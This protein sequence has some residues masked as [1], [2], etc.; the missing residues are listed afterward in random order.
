MPSTLATVPTIARSS[1][2]GLAH[3]RDERNPTAKYHSFLQRERRT[4]ACI[5]SHGTPSVGPP[6]QHLCRV[7]PPKM[8]FSPA[9]LRRRYNSKSKTFRESVGGHWSW[10]PGSSCSCSGYPWEPV[11]RYTGRRESGTCTHRHKP[12]QPRRPTPHLCKNG[13]PLCTFRIRTGDNSIRSTKYLPNQIQ[14]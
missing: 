9:G 7:I 5:L 2:P 8:I 4:P 3:A 13:P 1:C 12:H 14:S 6:T 10:F 11:S